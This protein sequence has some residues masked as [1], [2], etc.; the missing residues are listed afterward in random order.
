VLDQN[1]QGALRDRAVTD[2][3]DLPIELDHD[4]SCLTRLGVNLSKSFAQDKR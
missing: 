1:W 3:Q 4:V 2:E